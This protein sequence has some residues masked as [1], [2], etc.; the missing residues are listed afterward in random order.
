M[1]S[2]EDFRRPGK[3]LEKLREIDNEAGISKKAEMKTKFNR[4]RKRITL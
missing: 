4:N 3:L 1:S 2:Q